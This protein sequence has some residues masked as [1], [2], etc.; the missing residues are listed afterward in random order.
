MNFFAKGRGPHTTHSIKPKMKQTY[1]K[2]D[3]LLMERSKNPY[4]LNN[5]ILTI[6]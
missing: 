1:L 6:V 5:N 2:L 3:I 4:D